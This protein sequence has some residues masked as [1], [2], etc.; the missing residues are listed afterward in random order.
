[1]KRLTPTEEA[2][3]DGRCPCCGR[4]VDDDP[5]HDRLNVAT[6][7]LCDACLDGEF[8]IYYCPYCGVTHDAAAGC[9]CEE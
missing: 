3:R 7:R 1:M 2:V 6:Q 5:T 4:V 9:D 8:T